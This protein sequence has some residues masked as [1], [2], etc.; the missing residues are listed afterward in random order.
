MQK[1]KIPE[2]KGFAGFP[3]G[4]EWLVTTNP[5]IVKKH[6]A[7]VYGKATVGAPPMSVPHLDTRN[8]M[9]KKA[10]LFGPFAVFSTKFLKNGSWFDILASFKVNNALP[11]VEAG[12]KNIDLTW[13]LL[14]QVVLSKEQ[15]M[16]MLRQ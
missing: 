1:S 13:Y 2:G 15:R 4:G 5:L 8:I 11:M 14:G 9:G 6:L 12:F 10:L 16:D 3:V 7:K